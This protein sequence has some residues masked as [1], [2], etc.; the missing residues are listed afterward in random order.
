MMQP[1]SASEAT[2]SL[3]FRLIDMIDPSEREVLRRCAAVRVIERDVYRV[4][5]AP[6]GEAVP[7]FD[8]LAAHSFVEPLSSDSFQVRDSFRDTFMQSWWGTTDPATGDIPEALRDLSMALAD[9]YERRGQ[10]YERLYHLTTADRTIAA[11]L[12]DTLFS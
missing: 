1:S 10:V 3:F 4:V 2:Q 5:L 6:G 11:D 7:S 12:F 9:Y 8:T